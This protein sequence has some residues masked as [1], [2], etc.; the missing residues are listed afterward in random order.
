MWLIPREDSFW[1]AAA[2]QLPV[3]KSDFV[4]SLD[5]PGMVLTGSKA[6]GQV[7][8][9]QGKS[10]KADWHYRDKYNK[11]VYSTHFPMDIVQ[12]KDVCPWTTPWF[13]ETDALESRQ[14]VENW[15][16]GK[17]CRAVSK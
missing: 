11:F 7:K 10:S 1:N 2:S 5:Q 17:L 16:T 13:C 6:S 15:S 12:K 14:G 9:F 3:E 8:L 4:R